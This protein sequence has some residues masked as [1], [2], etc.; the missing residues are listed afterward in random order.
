MREFL[1]HH[2]MKVRSSGNVLLK[3]QIRYMNFTLLELKKELDMLFKINIHFIDI[4]RRC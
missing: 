4:L 2:G 3:S 1:F